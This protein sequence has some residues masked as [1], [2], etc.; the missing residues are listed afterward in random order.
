MKHYA[1]QFE[2]KWQFPHAVGGIDGKH[3]NIR[4]PP[5]SG[6]E[7]FNYK[8][9]VFKDGKLKDTCKSDIFPRASE[10]HNCGISLP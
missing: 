10:L 1:D 3:V 5:N 9:I 4:A 7:Y 6:S 2:M 8:N